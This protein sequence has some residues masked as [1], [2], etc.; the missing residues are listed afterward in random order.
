[1]AAAQL[2]SEQTVAELAT[3]GRLDSALLR[4]LQALEQLAGDTVDAPPL[5]RQVAT[6]ALADVR[7]LAETDRAPTASPFTGPTLRD[8]LDAPWPNDDHRP[9][10][11]EET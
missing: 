7:D 4:C 11:S 10:P 5:V 8:E 3:A 2:A 9:D 1:M 6:V